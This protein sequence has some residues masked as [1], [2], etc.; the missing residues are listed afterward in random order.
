MRR[1]AH[2][3]DVCD[4]CR[5][6][7]RQLSAM[8]GLLRRERSSPK[9]PTA[10]FWADAYR[11]ARVSSADSRQ[12]KL[13]RSRNSV[14]RPKWRLAA[15]T[16]IALVV[17]AMSLLPTGTLRGIAPQ[18]AEAAPTVDVIALV[19]SHASSASDEPLADHQ[20]LSMVVSDITTLEACGNAI[21]C[22]SE[23]ANGALDA[24]PASN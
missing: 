2:H 24:E 19:D 1:L 8:K 6:M 5:E 18:Q 13:A 20:R 11:T 7:T 14:T 16:A 15:V 22:S 21:D 12:S 17:A 10:S 9:M 4:D 23:A 3:V